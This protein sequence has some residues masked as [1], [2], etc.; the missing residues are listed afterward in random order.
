MASP[1]VA[2]KL[3]PRRALLAVGGTD[4]RRFLQG[5]LTADVSEL[6]GGLGSEG[7]GVGAGGLGSASGGGGV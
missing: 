1:S 6:A 2:A 4:A 3:L 7:A 5:L